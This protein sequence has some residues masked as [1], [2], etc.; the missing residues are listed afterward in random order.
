MKRPI[1][2]YGARQTI[3]FEMIYIFIKGPG[4][5]RPYPRLFVELR[6]P[7]NGRVI[8]FLLI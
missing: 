6:S 3:P 2:V 5:I 1:K 8:C 7:F 4:I